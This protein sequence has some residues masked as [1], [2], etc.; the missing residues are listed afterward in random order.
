MSKVFERFR[1]HHPNNMY[2][3]GAGSLSGGHTATLFMRLSFSHT[4]TLPRSLFRSPHDACAPP[5][6]GSLSGGHTAGLTA[7]L[8]PPY[9]PASARAGEVALLQGF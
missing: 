6:A 2:D 9:G 3:C 8:A 1:V 7:T 4:H 5:L